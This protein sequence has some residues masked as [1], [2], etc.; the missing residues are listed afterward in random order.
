MSVDLRATAVDAFVDLEPA[1]ADFREQVLTGLRAPQKRI[2]A[3]FF[4]DEVGSRLFERICELEEYYPTR[5]EEAIL[6]EHTHR[7]GGLLPAE[8]SI[9]EFGSGSANKIRLLVKGLRAPRCYVPIDISRRHLLHNADDFA[10]DHPVITVAAVCADFTGTVKVDGIVPAGPR[11][12]FFPGS[13]V[14]NLT[15]DETIDFLKNAASTLGSGGFLVIG[16]DLKKDTTVLNAAYNDA[17]G[18]TAAFNLNLLRRINRE[19]DGTFELEDFVHRAFYRPD[20]G[21]IEM[22]LVSRR[23]QEVRV[24]NELFVFSEGETI[25]TENSYKYTTAEFQ[26]L[27]AVAGFS[28]ALTLTDPLHY[29]SVHCL[30]VAL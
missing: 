21:R 17:E 4:Y 30:E 27:A 29:F 8:A 16:V 3:K 1:L 20:L 15:P 5:T 7:L 24:D 23:Q 18:V 10:R 2:P 22:H 14:G 12:G 11:I 26:S 13:T 9:L 19:L 6:A 28:T 25:H